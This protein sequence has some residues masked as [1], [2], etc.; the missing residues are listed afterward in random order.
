MAM[1]NL[2]EGECGGTN[3]LMKLTSHYTQDKARRQEGFFHGQRQ[4]QGLVHGRPIQEA[5]ER[6]LVDEFLTGQRINMAPQTFHMGSLL[7]EMREIEEQEYRHAP[8]RG[9]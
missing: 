4:N 5:T 6:E 8:Q 1:R 9:E 3:S 7:Q 2:V